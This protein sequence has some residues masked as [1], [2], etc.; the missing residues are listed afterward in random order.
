MKIEN[1]CNATCYSIDSSGQYFETDHKS[2]HCKYIC[3][4]GYQRAADIKVG[5]KGIMKYKSTKTRGSW[6]FYKS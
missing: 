6:V 5:D 4:S 3:L 2:L 1:E